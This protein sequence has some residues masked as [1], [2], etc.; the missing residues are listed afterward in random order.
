MFKFNGELVRKAH[1][2]TKKMKKEF[3]NINYQFQFGLEMKYLLS[4]IKEVENIM[5]ELK[6]SKKQVAWAKKIYE[7]DFLG[8]Y[9]KF[10]E[11]RLA[12]VKGLEQEAK[13][14]MDEIEK[15]D[16]AVWFI[17]Y[18]TGNIPFKGGFDNMIRRI[19]KGE[20]I[21]TVLNL[22]EYRY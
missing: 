20:S 1:K 14:L 11:T 7:K 6:G 17:D 13:V 5:V 18:R 19:W 22:G 21:D 9:K 8:E 4:N 12:G 10:P 15:I 2:E 16:N 3:P